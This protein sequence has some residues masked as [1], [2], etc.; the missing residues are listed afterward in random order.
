VGELE[1]AMVVE[2]VGFELGSVDGV[3]LGPEKGCVLGTEEGF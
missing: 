3:S 1:G 2:T